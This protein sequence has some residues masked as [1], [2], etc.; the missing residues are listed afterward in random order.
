[1]NSFC[2]ELFY[3][4]TT[5][6]VLFIFIRLHLDKPKF[7]ESHQT[8][9]VHFGDNV[10]LDCSTTSLPEPTITWIK[11]DSDGCFANFSKTSGDK[12]E[13]KNIQPVDAGTYQ[14]TA[15]NAVGTSV[16]TITITSTGYFAHFISYL[17]ISKSYST[18]SV[19]KL[20]QR[21][22]VIRPLFSL[23]TLFTFYCYFKRG[24]NH[25]NFHFF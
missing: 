19:Y 14:C 6:I 11:T 1:M 12:I 22:I 13:L 23:Q 5:T 7:K 2:A 25:L 4:K 15:E 10:L 17:D 24:Q 20:K 9:S 18:S 8:E 3:Q 21:L 16:K